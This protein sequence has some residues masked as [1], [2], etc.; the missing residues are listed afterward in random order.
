MLY[1]SF[2]F[3]L[4]IG[5]FLN[6]VIFRVYNQESLWW[7]RSR[8]LQCNHIIKWYDN[9][10]I[11]SFLRL[12]GKCRYCKHK[13]SWQY[14]LVE[15]S[16][17]IL[18]TI[19]AWQFNDNPELNNL[20]LWRNLLF[21][22]ILIVIF[23]MDFNWYVILDVITLPSILIV[24]LINLY[25]GFGFKNLGLAMFIGFIF[26]FLQ[27]IISSGKWLGAG[28]IRMGALMGAMLGY[29]AIIIA[30]FLSYIIGGVFSLGLLIRKTKQLDSQ[31]PLGTFL[32]IG[33]ILELL[34][35]IHD[36]F[37]IF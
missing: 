23:V 9:I 36:K 27:W 10:P 3:G 8:C 6:V 11:F 7:S 21:I 17:A 25:L 30:L 14:P 18:F 4:I 34:F 29:P 1:V 5:S 12:Q 28:D 24:I 15:L 2:I 20:M 26:F 19:T 13:I 32:S 35:N 16:C 31:I 37:V 33:T 22:S